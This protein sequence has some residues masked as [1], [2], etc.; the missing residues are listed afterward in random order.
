[1]FISYLEK[2]K[3][4]DN[5][6]I[7]EFILSTK[8][9]GKFSRLS[10]EEC[11]KLLKLARNNRPE[12]KVYFEW[13]C[14]Q[15]QEVFEQKVT[16]LN[17]LDLNKFDG[18]RVGEIG[19]FNWVL[20]ETNLPIHLIL[21]NGHHNL[22]G[23]AAWE[24]HAGKRLERLVLGLELPKEILSKYT[25]VLQTP[26]EIQV[27]GELQLFYSPRSLLK[28]QLD[29]S[30]VNHKEQW[31][32]AGANSE[33]SPHR[34]FT[35]IENTH[36]SFMLNPKKQSLLNNLNDVDD[37]GVSYKRIDTRLWDLDL[38]NFNFEQSSLLEL[39]PNE[40][41]I[42]GYFNV[43]KTDK[44]FVKLKN[45][46]LQ[47]K[48]ENFVG[49]IVDVKRDQYLAVKIE[50]RKADVSLGKKIDL[51]TP[52]GKVKSMPLRSIKNISLEEI[53]KVSKENIVLIPHISGVSVK[54]RVN[55]AETH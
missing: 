38:S 13:D 49:T 43:N 28:K 15:T 22:K 32:Q 6:R 33:E 37:C 16:D 54:T 55:L 46:R 35:I 18:I 9:F 40:K 7:S 29:F 31:Y 52:E 11:F 30:L 3:D 45:Y 19:A 51:S 50:N 24:K 17:S 26:V 41:F 36:G 48:D 34:G 4:L 14:L 47:R 21:E 27:L 53:E 25:K 1:M 23:I 44:I 5:H 2:A 42:R 8:N 12:V 20:Q 10:N 39:L